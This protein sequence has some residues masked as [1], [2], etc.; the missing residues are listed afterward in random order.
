MGRLP[1]LKFGLTHYCHAIT[2]LR[3]HS[4]RSN[5][6][7]IVVLAVMP[8]LAIILYSGLE[9]RRRSIED[10]RQSILLLTHAMAE[11]Q[12][13]FSRSV[14]QVLSTLSFLPQVQRLDPEPCGEIFRA[15]LEQHPAYLNIALTDPAGQVLASGRPLRTRDLADRKHV[16]E[17]IGKKTFAIGEFI[18]SRTGSGT[19]AFAFAYPVLNPNK[20]LK[21]VLTAAIQLV[22]FGAFHEVSSLP[23]ESFVALT[24]YQGIRLFYY[25]PH[26]D[27]NPIG[28]P[29][30]RSSWEKA[31]QAGGKGIFVG[32]G[33]D[34]TQRI[35][36]FEPVR[37]KPDDAPYLY[38]WAGIPEA[39]VLAPANATLKRNLL[40]LVAVALLALF[41]ARLIGKK[42]LI[43]PIE[44][45]VDLSRQYAR[46]DLAARSELTTAP[47]E[48]LT[49]TKAFHDMAA[50]LTRNQRTLRESEDRFKRLFEYAPEA[51]YL[52]DSEGRFLDGNKKGEELL[53]YRR[54]ELI[55]K[56]FLELGLLPEDELPKAIDGLAENLQG[57]ATGPEEFTLLRK[58]GSHV[59]V[60]ISTIPIMIGD[61]QIVLGIAR[62]ITERKRAAEALGESEEKLARSKK[63]ESLGL[64]AGGVAHDLNNVLSGIVSYPEL[65]LLD[66]PPDSKWRKPIETIQ[67]SGKRA[68]DIVQ[69]LLTVARG[70]AM[71]RQSVNINDQIEHY[72]H[73]PEF[74]QIKQLYPSVAVK[75]NLAGDLLG[76]VGS[77]VHIG[78]VV[79]NLVSNAVESI[80]GPGRVTLSTTNRYLD[81]PLKGYDDVAVGEY[82]VFSVADNGQ[83][84]SPEDLKRI[85]EPF[86]TKKVMGRSGTGLG[87][88]VVWNIMMDHKGYIDVRTGEKGT[89]FAL[90]FPAAREELPAKMLPIAAQNNQGCGQTILVVDDESSQREISCRMLEV[91]GYRPHAVASGEEAVDYLRTNTVDLVLLDMIMDPGLNGRETYAQI[92][93]RHPGQKAIIVSGFAETDDVLEA[94]RLGAGQY[95]KKPVTLEKLGLAVKKE[96]EK[97]PA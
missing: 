65:L 49:L 45:L 78:K 11:A 37:F 21:G 20:S 71:P 23:D 4:I 95:L 57:K 40:L 48:F 27:T 82:V 5:L 97:Q 13:D 25:P 47:E 31:R 56:N 90:Y 12:Q 53:G 61:Q 16:R 81:R 87:L 93:K 96:L 30:S 55:G 66:L 1:D 22:N 26:K 36:A 91:L 35:F 14:R 89:V 15:I 79:M 74:D 43:S 92:V 54:H 64:L 76:I 6:F 46:G 86:Y 85:F 3:L 19:P 88:A 2:M 18:V 38:V 75:T 83:G 68:V 24:D 94:Q 28:E 72:L 9:E 17:A 32:R 33:S 67:E 50:A 77:P 42:T 34:G 60:E 29:V 52:S 80:K 44:S 51:Y 70:V 10:A 73:S 63:M 7:V 8:A 39:Y 41:I 84:I 69:D 59:I 62:D 58:D